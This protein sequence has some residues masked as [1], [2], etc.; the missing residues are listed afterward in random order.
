[1]SGVE[2]EHEFGAAV[3][4]ESSEGVSGCAGVLE[5]VGAWTDEASGE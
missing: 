5:P 4:G 1:M 2:G 3:D